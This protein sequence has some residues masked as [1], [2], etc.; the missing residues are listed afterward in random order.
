MSL[1]KISKFVL[2]VTIFFGASYWLLE[3]YRDGDQVHYWR[4]YDVL[5]FASPSEVMDLARGYVNSGE[6]VSAYILFAGAKL[7]IYKS[8]Y[9]SII[10]VIFLWSIYL[11]LKRFRQPWYIYMLL[12][13]NFYV[14]VLLTSAERL[15]ISF[16]VLLLSVLIPREFRL[17]FTL[18]SILAHFQSI[19]LLFSLYLAGQFANIRAFLSTL[20]ASKSILFS[21]LLVL[22]FSSLVFYFISSDVFAKGSDYAAKAQ[23]FSSLANIFLLLIVAGLATRDRFRMLFALFPLVLGVYFLGGDRVNMIAFCVAFYLLLME[24]RLVS[25]LFVLLLIYLSLKSVPF[26]SNVYN[27]GY[28]W[29]GWLF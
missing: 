14:I 12:Y 4:F 20:K 21:F 17:P 2:L 7:G 8:T 3:M 28:G 26:V 18:A 23:S 15:K 27:Y 13:S 16:V 19:L 11:L 24:Q 5:Q 1:Y 10:N 6:P 29:G 9:I 22:S 25:P